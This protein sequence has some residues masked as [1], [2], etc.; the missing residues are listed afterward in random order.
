LAGKFSSADFTKECENVRRIKGQ[1]KM[2]KWLPFFVGARA[3]NR[4]IGFFS[5]LFIIFFVLK[6]YCILKKKEIG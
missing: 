4:T 6:F 3:G 1:G 2:P 5:S